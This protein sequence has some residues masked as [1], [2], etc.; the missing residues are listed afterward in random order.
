MTQF[1]HSFY[2]ATQLDARQ[3]VSFLYWGETETWV[4]EVI[5]VLSTKL[6]M[7][8]A[9]DNSLDTLTLH[10]AVP[11]CVSDHEPVAYLCLFLP[12]AGRDR[13]DPRGISM[14]KSIMLHIR[15]ACCASSQS[16]SPPCSG[17]SAHVCL[18]CLKA[19]RATK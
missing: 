11:V 6:K 10:S 16:T 9:E 7:T 8:F 13:A 14:N 4:L 1:T 19:P 17:T 5:C 12:S 18:C 3:F 2:N 15:N